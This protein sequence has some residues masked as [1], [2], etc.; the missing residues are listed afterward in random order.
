[1]KT[2]IKPKKMSVLL[3]C[4]M[5]FIFIVPIAFRT[6]PYFSIEKMKYIKYEL[7]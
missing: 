2:D 6:S 3:Y 7:R 1:M 5:L 4:F